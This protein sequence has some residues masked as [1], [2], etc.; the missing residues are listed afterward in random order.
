[1]NE[2]II[3]K[4]IDY[5]EKSSLVYLYTKYGLDSILVRG[6]KSYKSGNMRFCEVLNI[7]RYECSN[8]SLK[9]LLNYEIIDDLKNIKNSFNKLKYASIIIDILRQVNDDRTIKIY[10]F[11]KFILQQI[12]LNKDELSMCFIYLVKM[13]KVFGI[14]P[15]INNIN[16]GDLNFNNLVKEA[17]LNK[18]YNLII[19]DINK[20][21]IL[22][23]YYNKCEVINTF[24]L[25]KILGD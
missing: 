11:T 10:D 14:M 7:V 21:K 15:S 18:D 23:N 16:I 24:N 8:T 25:F 9:C 3:Y 17:Y 20:L 6:A 4:I 12:N 5:K 1:M 2:G 13:L 19:N 22:I